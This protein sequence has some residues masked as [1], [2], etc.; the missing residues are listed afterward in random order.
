MRRMR[1]EIKPLGRVRRFLAE[2]PQSVA[3]HNG[4]MITAAK[5]RNEW[6]EN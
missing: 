6:I 3:I 1:W 5:Q 4:A 2:G